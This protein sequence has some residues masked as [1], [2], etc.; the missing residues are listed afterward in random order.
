MTDIQLEVSVA[1]ANLLLE[2]LGNLPF[3]RVHELIAKIQRQAKRSLEPA[4]VPSPS[5]E[6]DPE[7]IAS[8]ETSAR[9]EVRLQD[10]F[11]ERRP[12]EPVEDSLS[13]LD[14]EPLEEAPHV[15]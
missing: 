9:D 1:E 7:P 10:L 2:G 13:S 5:F 3:V 8:A 15:S 6:P 4:P 11:P 14:V 12:E